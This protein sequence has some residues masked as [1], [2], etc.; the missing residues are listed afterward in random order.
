[1]QNTVYNIQ[2]GKVEVPTAPSGHTVSMEQ[3]QVIATFME[4]LCDNGYAID[5]K[6]LSALSRLDDKTLK[7]VTTN[8]ITS[9]KSL[10]LGKTFKC[11]YKGFPESVMEASDVELW[12]GAMI[13][14]LSNGTLSLVLDGDDKVRPALETK[15]CHKLGLINPAEKNTLLHNLVYSQIVWT[16]DQKEWVLKNLSADAL[17]HMLDKEPRIPNHTNASVLAG[18]FFYKNVARQLLLTQTDVLRLASYLYLDDPMLEKKNMFL[19]IPRAA[20]KRLME[21][22]DAVTHGSEDMRRYEGHWKR[23]S[24]AIHPAE[25]P[26]YE[27]ALQAFQQ[28]WGGMLDKSYHSRLEQ[29]ILSNSID[30]TLSLLSAR[31]GEFTRALS[32][33]LHMW[34]EESQRIV[35][36]FFEVIGKVDVSKLLSVLEY[37]MNENLPYRVFSP[38][39]GRAPY[40]INDMVEPLPEAVSKAISVGITAELMRRF[41]DLKPLGKV[42]IDPALRGLCI[43]K[44]QTTTS[45]SLKSMVRG[46]RLKIRDDVN[47]IRAF[48]FWK[49][50]VVSGHSIRTDIDLSAAMYDE[51]WS[52]VDHVAYTNLRCNYAYHSGD[53][54]DAPEGAAEY[55]DIDL[56]RISKAVRYILFTAN[57]YAGPAFVNIDPCSAGWIER[58]GLNDGEIWEPTTVENQY[59]INAN[60]KAVSMYAIDV[61][62]REIIW[63]DRQSSKTFSGPINNV[64]TRKEAQKAAVR[65]EIE[66][67]HFSL[68]NLF[69]LHTQARGTLV[70]RAE[71][72]DFKIMCGG[73]VDPY[74]MAAIAAEW[75]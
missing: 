48:V 56:R 1:M 64:L 69:L 65:A 75:L 18:K 29:A 25:Y 8:I 21:L 14:Y 43:P 12:F 58:K 73:D 34:P 74:D 59:S 28:L 27:H 4:I 66:K 36:S 60:T 49:N 20:R 50:A 22:L 52:M 9:L 33:I 6:V 30:D 26:Q 39:G 5:N 42:Y 32:R 72:A 55:I 35:A 10:S 45:G 71:D 15:H 68:Y 70:N 62:T 41:A 38:R 19:G 16:P 51:D 11:M 61:A 53:I 17:S 31:P 57:V 67:E 37:T 2:I 40:C 3:L 44:G 23:L 63:I 47:V 46:S 24:S 54:V 13:H 7:S